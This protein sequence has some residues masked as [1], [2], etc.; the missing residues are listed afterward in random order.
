MACQSEPI[1]IYSNYSERV[2]QNAL[3]R[4]AIA[5]LARRRTAQID[6]VV[7]TID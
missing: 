5:V 6:V 1:A 2:G 4:S 7:I 3:K